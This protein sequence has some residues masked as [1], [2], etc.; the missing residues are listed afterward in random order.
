MFE[1]RGVQS[2][3]LVKSILMS[4]TKAAIYTEQENDEEIIKWIEN[5]K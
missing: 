5:A 2:V 4:L 1:E 3:D